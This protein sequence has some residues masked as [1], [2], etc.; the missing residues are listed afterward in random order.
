MKTSQTNRNPQHVRQHRLTG[1]SASRPRPRP[2][3]RSR[4]R[5]RCVCVSCVHCRSNCRHVQI[6]LNSD[7]HNRRRQTHRP[8]VPLRS[9]RRSRRDDLEETNT[10]VSLF[11]PFS[12]S[13]ASQPVRC[14]FMNHLHVCAAT[15]RL[16]LE[17]NT[18]ERRSRDPLV[19]AATT[20]PS[21]LLIAAALPLRAD[22]GGTSPRLRLISS[23]R[24]V[25]V[26][27]ILLRRAATCRVT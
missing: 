24:L 9:S 13:S 8:N 23:T 4:S 26:V 19:T 16:S 15:I 12:N 14:Q 11:T 17:I 10:D 22:H 6:S 20:E 7:E 1:S 5:S 25:G 2:G 27:F 3:S 18:S 21:H